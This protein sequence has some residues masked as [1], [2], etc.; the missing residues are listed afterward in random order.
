MEKCIG[1]SMDTECCEPIVSQMGSTVWAACSLQPGSMG[2]DEKEK[3][4]FL[5]EDDKIS[6]RLHFM[7]EFCEW[8]WWGLRAIAWQ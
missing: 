3:T 4:C 5:A 2:S 7:F 8:S 6:N 1:Y